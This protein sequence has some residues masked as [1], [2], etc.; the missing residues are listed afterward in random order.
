MI[1]IA[2]FF[3]HWFLSLFTQS[4]FNHRYAAHE[5]FTMSKGWEKFFYILTYL[6][7]GSS[8]LSPRAYAIMHRK[9]HAHTDTEKDP[10]SPKYSNGLLDMMWKTKKEYSDYFYARKKNLEE[11]YLKNLPDWASLDRFADSW[12]NRIFWG[13]LYTIAYILCISVFHMPGTHWWMYFLLPIHYV[14]GPFHGVIINWFAHKV[15]YSN[16][17]QSNTSVNLF[18]FNFLMLGEGY[19]NNHHKYPNRANFAIKWYEFD[20]LYPTIKVLSWVRIIKMNPNA[21]SLNT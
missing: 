15:G 14:M 18:F 8:Y 2:I 9:H 3:A 5:Q 12:F 13:A 20:W 16:Y 1:I 6:F 21:K 4:F 7:Q 11:R 19:H 17:S 10:H